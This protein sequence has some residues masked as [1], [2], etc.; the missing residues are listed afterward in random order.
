MTKTKHAS[1]QKHVQRLTFWS[2]SLAMLVVLIV[3]A[4]IGYW[5]TQSKWQDT[6][7]W[8][9]NDLSWEITQ[10]Q[11]QATDNFDAYIA[12]ASQNPQI[13]HIN[14]LSG[15]RVISTFSRDN[16]PVAAYS[17]IQAELAADQ[18]AQIIIADSYSGLYTSYTPVLS[19][20]SSNSIP[21][22]LVLNY[23]FSSDWV[24]LLQQLAGLIVVMMLITLA[25][26]ILSKQL[27]QIL[28][29]KP[30][31]VIA[32]KVLSA[33]KRNYA[34]PIQVR[35]KKEFVLV[36]NAVNE[37]QRRVKV[38]IDDLEHNQLLYRIFA[39]ALPQACAMVKMDGTIVTNFGPD[40]TLFASVAPGSRIMDYVPN[41]TDILMINKIRDCHGMRK[42]L[43]AEV[44]IGTE[45]TP[46]HYD[47]SF[48]P[49]TEPVVG[50]P[51]TLITAQNIS[52]R[53]IH[54]QTL[55]LLASVF[56]S[57]EAIV[58]TNANNQIIRINQEF[59]RVTGFDESELIQCNPDTYA[60]SKHDSKFW[61]T[62][63]NE[64][65]LNGSWVGELT[66]QTR[67]GVTIPI[68]QTV[69]TVRN[70][71]GV[72]DN[73]VIVFS[74]ISEQKKT[75]A[76]V[77][78]HANFDTLT[79]LPNRRLF[80]NQLTRSMSQ[81]ARHK[82]YC[83][84]IFVDLD[85]F[86]QINDSYGH[87]VGDQVL[88]QIAS[89]LKARIRK[90]DFVARLSGDEF[91]ILVNQLA[92]DEP[93]SAGKALQIANTIL[94]EIRLPIAT[95]QHNFL[96]TASIGITLFSGMEKTGYDIMRESDTAMYQSKT[97]GRNHIS[98]F[99]RD[100]QAKVKNTLH[101]AH[102]ISHAI[103]N[104]EFSLFYQPQFNEYNDMVGMEALVRWESDT[105]ESLPPSEFIPVAEQNG[106]IVA[107]GD[108]ILRQALKDLKLMIDMG[109]PDTF[110]RVA[111]NISPR[112]FLDGD[113]ESRIRSAIHATGVP[114][115]RVELEIT[116]SSLMDHGETSQ[117]VLENLKNMGF[118]FA[119]DDFGTGYSSLAY[120]K[121][122]PID[123]LKIDQYF[124]RDIATNQS[125]AQIVKTIISMAKAMGLHVIAEGVET[126]SQL[127]FLRENDC[128]EFQGYYFSKP[129]S[130]NDLVG[131]YF[132]KK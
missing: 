111:I 2:T 11:R 65:L 49:V 128:A 24:L 93:T 126:K 27:V 79:D 89:R 67:S 43:H 90:E 39:N 19:D 102:R 119:I 107:L 31:G 17:G 108:F 73:F 95:D 70:A 50:E 47:F 37:M 75:M 96:T 86:K 115:A 52:Q 99:S 8:T 64:V 20:I 42:T 113:F 10:G 29:L 6:I 101:L 13:S 38:T 125:D 117:Q 92:D 40:D 72:V 25:L 30:L 77:R 105:G 98:F 15:N 69:S 116:E 84:L 34:D 129:L 48:T 80:M 44:N 132:M 3:S 97:N 112:Q 51:V 59:C 74:D 63:W 33:Q 71:Q 36:A 110:G 66:I 16:A 121:S 118:S 78:Y 53:K 114:P 124:V 130:F 76:M 22:L 109:L 88:L 18:N 4:G 83:A 57:R 81:A 85:N 1:L 122:L 46:V 23:D 62:I 54:E 7:T 104:Q 68:R 58:I 106:K 56:E 87:P 55:S 127:D 94:Q 5:N 21:L 91:V 100:M 120:L 45:D 28:V 103:D 131:T 9:L 123:K 32:Q 41:H 61:D 60:S 12:H 26:H 14:L 35:G 82:Y